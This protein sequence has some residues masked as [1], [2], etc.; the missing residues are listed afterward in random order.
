MIFSKTILKL[1]Q[2]STRWNK[3]ITKIVLVVVA[4]FTT[5]ICVDYFLLPHK[6]VDDTIIGHAK[7][8]QKRHTYGI[9]S[10][11][12]VGYRFYTHNGFK[13]TTDEIYISATDIVVVHTFFLKNVVKITT[14]EKEYKDNLMSGVTGINIYIYL[15]LSVSSILSLL[16][17]ISN[18]PLSDNTVANI[19]LFNGF[20]LI[21]LFIIWAQL[22]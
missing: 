12:T 11:R 20:M 16:L 13:F 7:L 10:T 21:I 18:K 15:I 3:T 22:Q 17:L 14:P 5:F 1:S 6:K 9:S 19:I 2:I 4:C 8:I